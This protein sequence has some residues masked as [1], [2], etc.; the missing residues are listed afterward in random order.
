MRSCT[1][2]SVQKILAVTSLS[3]LKLNT[4]KKKLQPLTP[5]LSPHLFL[6]WSLEETVKSLCEAA[7]AYSK[8]PDPLKYCFVTLA[9]PVFAIMYDIISIR[10][11]VKWKLFQSG[12]TGE[13]KLLTFCN[14]T[15]N[16]ELSLTATSNRFSLC[17]SSIKALNIVI[18]MTLY[19]EICLL[20]VPKVPHCCFEPQKCISVAYYC[21]EGRF[22]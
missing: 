8:T 1:R 13:S 16:V 22:R 2:L 15:G 7:A 3:S 17:F 10:Q 21:G 18:K 4:S 6:S 5:S 11:C 14:F 19:P 12:M 9:S 20:K